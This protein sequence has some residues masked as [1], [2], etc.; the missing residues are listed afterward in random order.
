M[1]VVG[2]HHTGFSVSNLE[3]SLAF[4]VDLL[5]CQVL[6]QREITP[7]WFQEVVAVPGC[8]VKR[9]QL[10]IPGS[11]HVLE[12]MEYATPR[13]VAVDSQ[14]NNPG[15]PHLC[16]LVD[17]LGVTHQELQARGVRFRSPPVPI[18]DGAGAGGQALYLIDPDGIIVELY[19]PPR[20]A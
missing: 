6:W 12:L 16:L 14:P 7:G 20:P 3:R 17:D 18:T 10:R 5:G 11:E 13:G 1:K 19:Q 9:A 4:Y 15:V 8:L 2:A